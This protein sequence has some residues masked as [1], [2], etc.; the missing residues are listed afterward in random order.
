MIPQ[1]LYAGDLFSQSP[2]RTCPEH[3]R[4]LPARS[5]PILSASVESILLRVRWRWRFAARMPRHCLQGCKRYGRVGC[6]PALLLRGGRRRSRGV[7]Y[8]CKY[9]ST[10]SMRE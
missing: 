2:F 8:L 5:A 10:A 7:A 1:R 6:A 4:A 9:F 3:I